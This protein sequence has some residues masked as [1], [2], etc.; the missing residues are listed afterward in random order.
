MKD[1]AIA[2][3]YG[4]TQEA[5]HAKRVEREGAAATEEASERA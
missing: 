4:I 3:Y 2:A 1:I 5:A